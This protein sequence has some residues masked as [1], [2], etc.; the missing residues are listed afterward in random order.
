MTNENPKPQG[1]DIF[2]GRYLV[3]ARPF[4]S[5]EP[6]RYYLAGPLLENNPTGGARFVATDGHTM[7]IWHDSNAV[8]APGTKI[9]LPLVKE[10]LAKITQRKGTVWV[11]LDHAV[12]ESLVR[13]LVVIRTTTIEQAIA[14]RNSNAVQCFEFTTEIV[15]IDGT[16]PDYTRV[17]PDMTGKFAAGDVPG[18]NARLLARFAAQGDEKYSTMVTIYRKEIEGFPWTILVSGREDF[19]G[20]LMPA[21]VENKKEYPEWFAPKGEWPAETEAA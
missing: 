18:F 16:Y 9:I 4:C 7:G 5:T 13:R 21:R 6:T 19:V 15:L 12:N 8:L 20:V 17:V 11:C 1:Y 10:V 14:Y 3:D 2:D